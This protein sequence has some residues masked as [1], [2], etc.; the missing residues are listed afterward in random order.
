MFGGVQIIFSEAVTAPPYT[1]VR[2]RRLS[3]IKD[4][5]NRFV[6]RELSI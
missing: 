3:K 4:F 6:S 5:F 1:S 2:L